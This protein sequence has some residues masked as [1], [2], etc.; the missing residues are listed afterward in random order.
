MQKI[1]DEILSRH[2]EM[3]KGASNSRLE[4][5]ISKLTIELEN[6]SMSFALA[7]RRLEKVCDMIWQVLSEQNYTGPLL[8]CSEN[9]TTSGQLLCRATFRNG[10]TNDFRRFF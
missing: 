10:M 3:R 1:L 7:G 9:G 5:R 8:I 2:Q 6:A 4:V